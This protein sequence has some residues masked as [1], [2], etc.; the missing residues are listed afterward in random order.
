MDK[1]ADKQ[2]MSVEHHCLQLRYGHL[3][4]QNS[5]T[6]EMLTIS[7]EQHGQLVPVII[8]P[9]EEAHKWVL[10]DGYHRVKALK[11]LGKDTIEA[12]VWNCPI[13][14]ALMK[15]L[16]NHPTHTPGILEEALVLYELYTHHA[17]SQQEL[18][19]Q[20]GRKQ[21]WVSGRLSLVENLPDSIVDVLSKGTL[22]LWICVRI[23]APIARAMPEHAQCLLTYLL[24]HPTS[25]REMQ[26][27][28]DHYQGSNGQVRAR[29]VADPDLFFKAHRLTKTNAQTMAL[30]KGPEGEWEVRCQALSSLLSTLTA[31][32]PRIFFRQT[33]EARLKPLEEL[34]RAQAK[35]DELTQTVRGLTC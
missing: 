21:S 7:I 12:E 5:R 8:V 10:I 9:E 33:E 22:S 24:K 4:A 19:A 35:F 15:M 27:F 17:L 25:T 26:F 6:L 13:E 1:M 20:I 3:H 34:A 16:R 29:M 18:A 2:V 32:A 28:Y 30:K 23:L 14:E 31:L 11:R